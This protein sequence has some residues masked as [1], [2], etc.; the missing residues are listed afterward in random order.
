MSNA[1]MKTITSLPVEMIEMALNAEFNVPT[2]ALREMA[3]DIKTQ[4]PEDEMSDLAAMVM[5]TL[6]V[7]CMGVQQEVIDSVESRGRELESQAWS[8]SA[9]NAKLVGLMGRLLELTPDSLQK[10][11]IQAEFGQVIKTN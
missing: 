1:Q 11:M 7:G 5:A 4:M 9:S 10:T 2:K 8:L 6:Q 3:H